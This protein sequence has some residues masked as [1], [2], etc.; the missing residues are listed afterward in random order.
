[1]AARRVAYFH[2]ESVAVYASVEG[3][4][5]KP[6]VIKCGHSDTHLLSREPRGKESDDHPAPLL[7]SPQTTRA[8][9]A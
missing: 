5:L 9:L 4:M 1:M 2:D 3:A 6:H 7:A 8:R